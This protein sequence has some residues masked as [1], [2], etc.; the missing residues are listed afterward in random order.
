[1]KPGTPKGDAHEPGL[2][3]AIHVTE[4]R[5]FNLKAQPYGGALAGQIALPERPGLGVE[6][7]QDVIHP[8]L[9]D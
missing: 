7:D 8:Y 4:W 5:R 6:P 9:Q 1:L 3:A 2:L